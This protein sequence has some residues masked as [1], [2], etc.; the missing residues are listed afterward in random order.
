MEEGDTQSREPA[1]ETLAIVVSCPEGHRDD[2]FALLE[3]AGVRILYTRTG[4]ADTFFKVSAFKK[5]THPAFRRG[6]RQ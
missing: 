3:N 6:A 1:T 4:D 5:E 2:V